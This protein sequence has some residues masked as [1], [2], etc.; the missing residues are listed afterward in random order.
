MD[1]LIK[2]KPFYIDKL[3][4]YQHYNILNSDFDI[5]YI[6][7]TNINKMKCLSNKLSME[8]VTNSENFKIFYNFPF[9][10]Y[11]DDPYWIPPFWKEFNDFFR[12]S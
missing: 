9:Q 4:T 2:L 11:K 3:V 8:T 6:F 1:Y 10:L 12:K 7:K 5:D